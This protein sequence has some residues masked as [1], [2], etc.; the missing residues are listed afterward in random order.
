[1]R[2][3]QMRVRTLTTATAVAAL[4]IAAG[5]LAAPDAQPAAARVTFSKDVAPILHRSCVACHRPGEVA[6]MSLMTYEAARPWA[7]AIRAAVSSRT[8]P[9]WYADP[10]HGVFANDPRLSEPDIATLL[11]WVDGGAPEGNRRDLPASPVAADGWTLGRPDTVVA[12]TAPAEV[13]AS[14]TRIIADY[15]IQPLVFTED[16][17]VRAIEVLPS[18]RAVTHH[19]IVNVKDASGTQRIGGYQPGGATTVYPDGLV[20]LIPKGA[21]LALN[22]HYNPKGTPQQDTTRIGLTRATGRIDKVV[23]TAMSGT[24]A[25]DIPPGAAN[26]QA[27]GTPYVF[28]EDCHIIS[29]L[30]RMNERGKD[31]RYTL[32]YPDGRSV[33]LLSVPRFNPD[34]QPSYVLKEAIAAPKGSRLETVA[35]FDN[36]AANRRNPDPT[37]RVVFG[38]EIMNGYF[39]FTV[40]AHRPATSAR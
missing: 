25:L 31:Y 28:A 40:D 22:M 6:P 26:Y 13:P 4:S 15:P 24:R 11:A 2:G 39:D 12:M 37:Q 3:V 10:A 16:T 21:S 9:P 5:A 18:N 8:M 36:S 17:Y 1:M 32:V 20:R 7:K 29:L 23:R 34:W 14:G 38:P 19:A 33:V 35:H 30:P 27:V